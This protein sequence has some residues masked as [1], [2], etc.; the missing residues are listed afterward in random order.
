MD[1][2]VKA[3]LKFSRFKD[4]AKKQKSG[5]S[6]VVRKTAFDVLADYKENVPRDTGAAAASAYVRTRSA[7]GR[8]ESGKEAAYAEAAS[9][10]LAAGTE[11]QLASEPDPEVRALQAWIIVGVLYGAMLEYGTENMAPR[12][13]LIPAMNRVQG[14]FL[15]AIVQVMKNAK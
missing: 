13:T 8:Y 3:D 6:A 15:D 7:D 12:A 4:I 11:P 5:V 14:I 10:A 1:I 9:I 2:K